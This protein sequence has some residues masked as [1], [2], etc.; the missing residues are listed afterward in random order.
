MKHYSLPIL[1][2]FWGT[3]LLG[4]NNSNNSNGSTNSDTASKKTSLENTGASENFLMK[5]VGSGTE[6][7][8]FRKVWNAPGED[9]SKGVR[10]EFSKTVN[11]KAGITI[12]CRFTTLTKDTANSMVEMASVIVKKAN[13]DFAVTVDF[14]DQYNMGTEDEVTSFVMTN[15]YATLKPGARSTTKLEG[16]LVTAYSKD[17]SIEID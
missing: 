3:F 13:K 9:W 17:G 16:H 14:S 1:I 11:F 8:D 6:G 10:K 4:C 12:E 7:E 15:I 2:A 5:Q